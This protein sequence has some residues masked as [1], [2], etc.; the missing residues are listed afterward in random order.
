MV[1]KDSTPKQSKDWQKKELSWWADRQLNI[2]A[3]MSVIQVV[4]LALMML[5]MYINSKVF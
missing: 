4:M 3:T 1:N 5:V 2:V